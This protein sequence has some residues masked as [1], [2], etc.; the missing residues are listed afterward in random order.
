[1]L[2]QWAYDITNITDLSG[3]CFWPKPNVESRS[4]LMVK[5]ENF[6]CCEDPK[7]FMKVLRAIFMQRRKTIKNNLNA[8]TNS[9]EETEEILA[10]ANIDPTIRAEKLDIESILKLS[11]VY[12]KLKQES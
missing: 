4:V 9:T 6:P 7:T 11:D 10:K 5:K 1:V 8:I 12:Y 3:G 2:C